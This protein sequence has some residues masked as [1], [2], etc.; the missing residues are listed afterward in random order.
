MLN[1]E[2]SNDL[3]ESKIVIFLFLQGSNILYKSSIEK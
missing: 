2:I 3:V 1:M